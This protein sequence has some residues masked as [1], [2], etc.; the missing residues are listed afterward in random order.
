MDELKKHKLTEKLKVIECD[1]H[2]HRIDLKSIQAKLNTAYEYEDALLV[3]LE[4][5]RKK[6]K[7]LQIEFYTKSGVISQLYDQMKEIFDFWTGNFYTHL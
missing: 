4:T 7:E 3:R 1:I 2:D 6:T 5:A